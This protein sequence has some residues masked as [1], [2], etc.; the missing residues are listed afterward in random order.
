MEGAWMSC[1][2]RACRRRRMGLSSSSPREWAKQRK[3]PW[4]TAQLVQ[5]V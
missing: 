4:S 5:Y 3:D 2:T 1:T